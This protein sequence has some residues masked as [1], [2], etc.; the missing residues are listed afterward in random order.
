MLKSMSE[1][2]SKLRTEKADLERELMNRT[3]EISELKVRASQIS[4][5]SQTSSAEVSKLRSEFATKEE[6]FRRTIR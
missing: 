5:Q 2:E 1:R 4:S 6:S 3:N